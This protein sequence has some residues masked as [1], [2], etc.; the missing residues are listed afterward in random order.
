MIFAPALGAR[1]QKLLCR[2]RCTR[3]HTDTVGLGLVGQEP[4]SGYFAH[5][6]KPVND[7]EALD[8]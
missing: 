1:P 8:S 7:E 5:L 2:A 4:V 3:L 6:S